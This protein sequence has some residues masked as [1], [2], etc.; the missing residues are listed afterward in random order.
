VGLCSRCYRRDPASAASLFPHAI[1]YRRGTEMKFC[2]C[3]ILAS[4]LVFASVVCGQDQPTPVS[5][6]QLIANPQ[7]FDAKLVT[8]CGFLTIEH[9]KHHT[10][11]SF[12]FLH[13]EDAKHLLGLNSAEVSPSEQMVKDLE[14]LDGMYVTITGVLRIVPGPNGSQALVIRDV[15]SCSV[16]S[17]PRRPLGLRR[18][19][20]RDLDKK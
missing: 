8:T 14:K 15:R 20:E 9:E 16:W 12:L 19:D 11:R 10:P 6:V 13:Q 4:S 3:L 7:K 5:M 18:E 1:R 2:Q 17:D